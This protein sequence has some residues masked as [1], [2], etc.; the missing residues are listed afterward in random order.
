MSPPGSFSYLGVNDDTDTICFMLSSCL[1]SCSAQTSHSQ[2]GTMMSFK[3][4]TPNICPGDRKTKN[5]LKPKIMQTLQAISYHLASFSGSLTTANSTSFDFFWLHYWKLSLT[6][7]NLLTLLNFPPTFPGYPPNSWN[8]C[9]LLYWKYWKC[10]CHQQPVD[11]SPAEATYLPL[12]R[13][14]RSLSMHEQSDR[15]SGQSSHLET[16]LAGRC[17]HKG[18]VTWA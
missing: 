10:G 4:S 14:L 7:E 12:S 18:H 17:P 13:V 15:L 6:R 3:S 11:W 1:D 9:F 16:M 5:G 2:G 8:I